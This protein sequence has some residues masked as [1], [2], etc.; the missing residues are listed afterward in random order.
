MRWRRWRLAG[1]RE[2]ELQGWWERR[3]SPWT[4]V[5]DAAAMRIVV[6]ATV[7][8]LPVAVYRRLD[9][10][11]W[12][13]WVG[14]ERSSIEAGRVVDLNARYARSFRWAGPGDG[15]GDGGEDVRDRRGDAHDDGPGAG[16]DVDRGGVLRTRRRVVPVEGGAL[17]EGNVGT[18]MAAE[19][20]AVVALGGRRTGVGGV[21]KTQE[22]DR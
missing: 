21:V 2:E 4:T 8:Q 1:D 10:E 18:G 11:R 13:D 12:W 9:I 7:G 22:R 5:A 14:R 16:D 17:S 3:R 19:G 15:S 20:A 6:E